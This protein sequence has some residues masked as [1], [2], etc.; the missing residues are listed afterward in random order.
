MT[1]EG[2]AAVDWLEGLPE[3]E[4]MYHFRVPAGEVSG[5]F[6]VKHDHERSPAGNCYR[7]KGAE[8]NGTLVVIE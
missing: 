5:L 6:S 8:R 2:R 3:Y 4:H 7:C 1:D